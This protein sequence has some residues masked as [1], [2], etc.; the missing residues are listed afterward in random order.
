M[1]D[2]SSGELQK[3]MELQ[4][5]WAGFLADLDAALTSSV[6]VHCLG[7]FVLIAAYDIPRATG[8]LD[9]LLTFPSDVSTLLEN[10]GGLD[11]KL[12]KKHHVC[13]ER[14]GVSDLPEDYDSR[15]TELKFGLKHLRLLALNPYDLILSKLTRNSP[16]DVEDVKFLAR[17]QHLE[18]PVLYSIFEKEMKPWLPNLARHELT[19][20][21]W[22]E[23]FQP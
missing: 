4:K 20:R 13:V 3:S 6:E 22:E 2:K 14:V 11:S 5:P 17:T 12:A 10:L 8:D 1:R 19:L 18:F 21:I 23:Y 7:G 16:K 9:Y 15:L